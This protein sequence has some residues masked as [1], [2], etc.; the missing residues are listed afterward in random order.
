MTF[1]L[2]WNNQCHSVTEREREREVGSRVQTSPPIF[3]SALISDSGD[4][5]LA[6]GGCWGLRFRRRRFFRRGDAV[7][8]KSCC[9]EF[10]HKECQSS[11]WCGRSMVDRCRSQARIGGKTAMGVTAH[12]GMG[13]AKDSIAF[14]FL[15]GGWAPTRVTPKK[16]IL[17]Y[18]FPVRRR[19]SG[20]AWQCWFDILAF[21]LHRRS[22]NT[23]YVDFIIFHDE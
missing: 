13:V 7:E 22:T 14:R 16:G 17:T 1:L 19:H 20:V 11:H 9:K 4:F 21:P 23:N 12:S 3:V 15:T 8:N 5:G 18:G 6:W 10:G 2:A